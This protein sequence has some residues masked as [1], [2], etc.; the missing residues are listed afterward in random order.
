MLLK[1]RSPMQKKNYFISWTC[2]GIN[3]QNIQSIKYK[4]IITVLQVYIPLDVYHVH[5]I[6]K[7]NRYNK[8]QNKEGGILRTNEI[9]NSKID[10]TK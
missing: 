2:D 3:R 8:G 9:E 4:T 6:S 5:L 7:V 10:L 1:S